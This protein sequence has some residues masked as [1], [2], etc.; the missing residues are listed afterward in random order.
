MYYMFSIE[1][2]MLS[3]HVHSELQIKLLE[4]L[5]EQYIKVESFDESKI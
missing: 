5:L 2:K 3:S 4:K 1:I